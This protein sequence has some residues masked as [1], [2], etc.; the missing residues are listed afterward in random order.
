[1]RGTHWTGKSDGDG[2]LP[3]GA[4]MTVTAIIRSVNQFMRKYGCDRNTLVKFQ[5]K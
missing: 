1:M 3:K 4:S 5:E 2:H